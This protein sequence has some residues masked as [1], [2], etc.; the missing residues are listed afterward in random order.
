MYRKFF[1]SLIFTASVAAAL[2][3]CDD[4]NEP[5]A[6][7]ATDPTVG[8]T[9]LVYMAANNNLGS[10]YYDELDLNE[11][12]EGA[13]A[14]DI[15]A[16]G[17][18]LVYHSDYHKVPELLEVTATGLDTLKLYDYDGLSVSSERMLEVFDDLTELAPA[19]QYGIVLW[20]HATGWLQDGIADEMDAPLSPQSF[21]SDSGKT[22]NV[23]TLARTLE[24]GPDWSFVYF[25]CCYMGSVE[26]MYE[27][28]NAA[29]TIV[30]SVTEL[31]SRGMPYELNLK[32][33]FA[34]GEPDLIAAAK[35]TFN[36]YDQLAGQDRTCTMSVIST[37]GMDALAR[38]VKD[39]FSKANG[40]LPA[41]YVPQKF[42]NTT[43]WSCNYFDLRDY[44][45]T[46]CLDGEDER[47]DGASAAFA[48]FEDALDQA[49]LYEA[50]TP[51]LWNQVPLT[52]H[53][54][55]STFIMRTPDDAAH[56][57]YTTLSWWTDVASALTF[58]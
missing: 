48:G 3:S 11:M 51:R 10:N 47:F 24:A 43:T 39:I 49:V 9:V 12:L 2:S 53:C 25:D 23:T 46:L 29:P 17:R 15:G 38:S 50:A 18:L 13:K 7:P 8:R 6:P 52:E 21:G 57:A 34:E 41:G 5:D 14:G 54:G 45:R 28:R 36:S 1:L 16:D 40:T 33:F 31:P 22:M 42:T 37:A 20:S 56:K 19:R 58:E 4:N 55:L 26:T 32:H 44:L 30:A 27:L 35:E